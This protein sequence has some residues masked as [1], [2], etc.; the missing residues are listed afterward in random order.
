MI[1]NPRDVILVPTDLT[2]VADCAIDHATEIALIFKHKISLLHVISSRVKGTE[3]ENQ[4]REALKNIAKEIKIKTGLT[5]NYLV[6]EGTIFTTISEVANEIYAE[7]IVMGIHGKKG[8]QH[9]VG[10]YAYKVISSSKVPVLVVKKRHHHVGYNNIVVPI[11]FSRESSQKIWQTIKFAK[12][13]DANVWVLGFLSRKSTA[14]VLKKE[15]LLKQVTD[16]FTRN[17][18][19]AS[20]ELVIQ[21]GSD[22]PEV[23]LEYSKKKDADLIM[24]VAEKGGGISDIFSSN[25]AEKIIDKGDFPILTVI[26]NPVLEKED[27]ETNTIISPFIDPL[28]LIDKRG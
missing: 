18:V 27:I 6:R 7:F 3:K 4:I 17:Q 10:S 8:V 15:A 9:L 24:I 14:R 21:G 19:K 12:Y 25:S 26:P 5:V 13:F 28:G 23:V 11:D 20:A 2:G 1:Q 22:L 16:I